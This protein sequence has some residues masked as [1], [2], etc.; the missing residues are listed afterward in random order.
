MLVTMEEDAVSLRARE[1]TV[2]NTSE[3]PATRDPITV[4]NVASRA[5]G[6]VESIVL[7]AFHELPHWQRDNHFILYGYRRELNSFKGCFG[8]LWYLHNE[9]GIDPSTR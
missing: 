7:Y 3:P 8:S 5:I 1:A 9:T 4:G 6:K 2:V